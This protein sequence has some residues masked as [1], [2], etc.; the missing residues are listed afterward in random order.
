[1]RLGSGGATLKVGLFIGRFQPFHNGHL[2]AVRYAL[3][4]VDY[5]Y[6]VIGS[7]QKSHQRDNPFT[8]GERMAMVKDAL[9]GNGIDPKKW[10]MIPIPDAVSHAVW[11]ATVKS[12]VPKFDKVFSNDSLTVWLFREERI[13]TFVVPYLNRK[14][15]SATEV[16]N[17]ILE[18]KDWQKLVPPQV[19]KHIVR[20]NGVQRVRYSL[21][22]DMEAE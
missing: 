15:Y 1:V 5:L 17:R 7:A 9:D 3:K 18:R 16:R 19:A 10:M 13:P 20:L 14:E 6:I 8:A 22:K 4:R 21:S 11:V 2:S 12:M